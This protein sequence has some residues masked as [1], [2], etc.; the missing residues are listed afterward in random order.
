V[1]SLLDIPLAE[2]SLTATV[3]TDDGVQVISIDDRK[4]IVRTDTGVAF[5]IFKQNYPIHGYA[6]WCHNALEEIT[7]SGL[8]VGSAIL[9][10]QGAVA[11]VQA[12]LEETRTAAEGVK[13][14]PWITA[15]TSSDG[16]MATT[17]LLGTQVW[18]CDNTL[19]LALAEKDALRVKIRHTA[20][21]RDRRHEVRYNLGLQVEQIGDAF[22]AEIARLTSQY[23]SDSTWNEFV[24]SYTGVET[25]KDGRS[26]TMAETKVSILNKMWRIDERVAPWKNSAYG[27][28]AAVNTAV[29]HEFSVKGMERVERNMLRTLGGE[30]DQ[31]DAGV[32]R[33]LA[34][35]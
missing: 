29:H 6:D 35:V 8:Q 7:G 17:Y 23:V 33:I 10:K 2:A 20:N 12:E 11:A 22:D 15:A 27:V 26:K 25:A 28:V 21:S 31:L 13:H 5:G 3:L 19:A 18:V 32:L 1:L 4:A 14:R 24:K 30:W 16:S 9:L 34:S